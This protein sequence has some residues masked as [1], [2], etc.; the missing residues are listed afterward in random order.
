MRCSSACASK[1]V[2]AVYPPVYSS[3][4]AGRLGQT[5]C[6]P[7]L[8]GGKSKHRRSCLGRLVV[9]LCSRAHWRILSL[10]TGGFSLCSLEDSLSLSQLTGGFSLSLSAHWRILSLSA[11]W[12]ILSLQLTNHE[13]ELLAALKRTWGSFNLDPIILLSYLVSYHFGCTGLMQTFFLIDSVLIKN[14]SAVILWGN[15]S[16][17]CAL[18]YH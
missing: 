9:V 3:Y 6:T 18:F 2:K 10:L 4:Y 12:R 14:S 11:H 13:Q 8:I 17:Q 15:Y 1:W 16:C 5:V 7:N